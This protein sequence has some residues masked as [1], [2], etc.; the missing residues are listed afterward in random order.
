MI[1]TNRANHSASLQ[2]L[3][4]LSS[5]HLPLMPRRSKAEQGV[6]EQKPFLALRIAAVDAV[7]TICTC[8]QVEQTQPTTH[9]PRSRKW[10]TYGK[11]WSDK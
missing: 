6:K 8:S 4:A 1:E 7:E 9:A 11:S 10:A 2:Q 3:V 5:V